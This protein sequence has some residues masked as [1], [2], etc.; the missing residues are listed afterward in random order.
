MLKQA[1]NRS[2]FRFGGA[3]TPRPL[4]SKWAFGL[5]RVGYGPGSQQLIVRLLMGP[6]RIPIG[7]ATL[8]AQ[9]QFK[10]GLRSGIKAYSDARVLCIVG[11]SRSGFRA[12]F[13]RVLGPGSRF[14]VASLTP[15]IAC[16]ARQVDRWL[17]RSRTAADSVTP[18]LQL[19]GGRF[20]YGGAGAGTGGF[21]GQGGAPV[22][23][24][25]DPFHHMHQM[26][27]DR[28]EPAS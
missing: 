27:G 24:T 19:S 22:A 7:R 10:T 9:G 20:Q 18:F 21:P 16:S 4:V 15:S 6:H 5:L 13:A 11:H 25:V 14:Y 3:T 17:L 12:R 23:G 28:P 1:L 26:A 2:A 8:K